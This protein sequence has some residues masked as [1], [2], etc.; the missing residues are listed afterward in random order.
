MSKR[1]KR[2][3]VVIYYLVVLVVALTVYRLRLQSGPKH[4]PAVPVIPDRNPAR[5]EDT[6]NSVSDGVFCGK[7]VNHKMHGGT[8]F[9]ELVKGDTRYI[10]GITAHAEVV[11]HF[12][13]TEYTDLSVVEAWLSAR[14]GG[15]AAVGVHK[16]VVEMVIFHPPDGGD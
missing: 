13:H 12:P 2:W 14:P 15:T 1:T 9:I 5:D 16:G 8:L 10:F 7:V 4:P 3:L 6:F 11:S